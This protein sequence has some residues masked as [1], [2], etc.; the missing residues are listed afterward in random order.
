MPA[1]SGASSSLVAYS[2]DDILS[3]FCCCI[4]E[5]RGGSRKAHWT[6]GVGPHDRGLKALSTVID[7]DLGC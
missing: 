7:T 4:A 5:I 2:H 6:D 3:A 1:L